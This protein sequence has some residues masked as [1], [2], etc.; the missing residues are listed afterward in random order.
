MRV[1]PLPA[2]LVCQSLLG[3]QMYQTGLTAV[4]HKLVM[5]CMCSWGLIFL[6]PYQCLPAA[7]TYLCL[8][9]L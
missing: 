6:N 7:W 2:S 8:R 4:K 9:M 1:F 3:L 5:G